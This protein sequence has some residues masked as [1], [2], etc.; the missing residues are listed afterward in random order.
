MQL[1]GPKFKQFYTLQPQLQNF[2]LKR[3][4]CAFSRKKSYPEKTSHI[5]RNGTFQP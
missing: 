2:L 5:L 1:S 3:I 4:S